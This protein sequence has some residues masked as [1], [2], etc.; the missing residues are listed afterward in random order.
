MASD[1]IRLTPAQVPQA[2][3]DIASLRRRGDSDRRSAAEAPQAAVDRLQVRMR[4][5]A[6]ELFGSGKVLALPDAEMLAGA[7]RFVR[8]AGLGLGR[9]PYQMLPMQ[10]L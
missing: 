3:A 10:V 4:T 2:Q 6:G 7:L 1:T 9:R 8:T 5:H